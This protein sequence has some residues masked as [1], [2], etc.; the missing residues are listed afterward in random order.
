MSR[1]HAPR[2]PRCAVAVALTILSGTA[3]ADTTL[4]RAG[5]VKD[6][7]AGKVL[8]DQLIRIEDGRITSITSA[9]AAGSAARYMNKETDFGSITVG[10][11]ADMIAVEGDPLANIDLLR[12]IAHVMKE[13]KVVK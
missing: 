9:S 11:R 12:T 3:L 10:K 5:R 7:D 13:G 1:I 6:V 8:N 4:V 2:L